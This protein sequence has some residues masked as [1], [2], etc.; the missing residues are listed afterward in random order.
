MSEAILD[1]K[2]A[3]AR[4]DTTRGLYVK[5]LRKKLEAAEGKFLINT[6]RGVGYKLEIK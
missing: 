5:L 1:W 6:I 4:V 2:E 3:M